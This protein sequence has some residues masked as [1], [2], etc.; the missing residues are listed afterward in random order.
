MISLVTS[1]A[2]RGKLKANRYIN[3]VGVHR[4]E[5]VKSAQI[6]PTDQM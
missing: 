4:D 6:Q 3:S 5:E 2:E 1:I